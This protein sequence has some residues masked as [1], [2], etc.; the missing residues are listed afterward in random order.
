M[1]ALPFWNKEYQIAQEI[2]AILQHSKRKRD[3]G[4]VR[5]LIPLRISL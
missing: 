3:K 1:F 2:K 4:R 5:V